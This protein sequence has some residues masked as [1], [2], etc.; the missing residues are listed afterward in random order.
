MPKRLVTLVLVACWIAV[1]AQADARQASAAEKYV[2]TWAGTYDGAGTGTIELM[3]DKKD[4]AIAG[5]VS[6]ATDGG[7]YTADL[8]DV[9]FD[10]AKMSASYDFPLD[11][12]AEVV[13]TA[14]FDGSSA[15]GT[16]SLRA[17]GTTDEV[18]GGGIAIAKK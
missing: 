14:T 1:A 9:T 5:K 4:G 13:L 12:S 17:K 10:G 8:K 11:P 18:A 2:G 16:W 6:A 15:K 7:N 3:L